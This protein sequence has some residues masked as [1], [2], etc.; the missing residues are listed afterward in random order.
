MLVG[1]SVKISVA[2]ML[3]LC[4]ATSASALNMSNICLLVGDGYSIASDTSCSNYYTCS[5]GMATPQSCGSSL[6]F[7]K[8]QQTCVSPSQV[9]CLLDD[10]APCVNNQIGTWAPMA[11]SCSGFYYCGANGP[12]AGSCPDG[13][14]FDA[15]SQICQYASVLG[16]S[17]T[18]GGSGSGDSADG[19]GTV[20]IN[21][22]SFIQ[23]GVYFGSTS[24]CSGWNTCTNNIMTS[25][26][27]GNALVFNVHLRM[28][29]YVSDWGCSQVTHD[30][31]LVGSGGGAATTGGSC[32]QQ[33]LMKVSAQCDSFYLCDGATYQL[34]Q[35]PTGLY[36]DTISQTCVTRTMAHNNCD[37]CEG[38]TMSF[39]NA[40][41]TVNCKSYLYCQNG[42]EVST[43][44]CQTGYFDEVAGACLTGT[45]VT[46]PLYACCNPNVDGTTVLPGTGTTPDGSDSSGS[47]P[48]NAPGSDSTPA[49]TP[50]ATDATPTPTAAPTDTTPTDTTPAPAG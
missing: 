47:G 46:E 5:G 23:N 32:Q 48:T 20:S 30:P 33:G 37:R 36:Y 14:N 40:Y 10:S 38:T 49:G 50:A 25:G 26:V 19:D 34:N 4:C 9:N 39:V 31:N 35:C 43:G 16:C 41:S 7:S 29:D 13:E 44:T 1:A 8:D 27:C 42:V 45:N 11:N 24:A 18:S 12:L 21:L 2:L 6:Y 15:V 3:T 28:C 22:C 17:S